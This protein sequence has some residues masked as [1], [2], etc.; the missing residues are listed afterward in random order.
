LLSVVAVSGLVLIGSK[1][2]IFL[3]IGINL[4][5]LGVELP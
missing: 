1:V 3:I 5:P 2:L 4:S